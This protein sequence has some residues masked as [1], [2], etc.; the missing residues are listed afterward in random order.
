[1]KNCSV[2]CF[3]M[4]LFVGCNVLNS[5]KNTS[6]VPD[7]MVEEQIAIDS[8]MAVDEF[9]FAINEAKSQAEDEKAIEKSEEVSGM[10]VTKKVKKPKF[11]GN[12][13]VSEDILKTVK[14]DTIE[15]VKHIEKLSDIGGFAYYVPTTMRVDSEYRV[16]LRISKKLSKSITIGFVDESAV[17]VKNVRVGDRMS[18]KLLETNSSVKSFEITNLN[19]EIQSVED[20]TSFTT[21]EWSVRP[22]KSGNHKLKMIVVITGDNFT[23]D[24]PVYEGDIHIKSYLPF[25]IK[26]FVVD[27]W[28]VLL[29]PVIIPFIIF[30]WK[31]RKK[32]KVNDG[33]E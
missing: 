30:L 3:I 16:T 4:L 31:N 12:K 25:T 26:T 21:W 18:V 28:K 29:S 24:I 27:N 19:S 2:L 11:I 6:Q 22:I 23:K 20:D 5:C 14:V 13:S 9:E 1:M 17:V 33:E 10:K 8:A 32:K 15:V 7:V